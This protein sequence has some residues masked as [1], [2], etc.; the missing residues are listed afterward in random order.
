MGKFQYTYSDPTISTSANGD[1]PYGIYDNDTAFV[2][3]SVDVC[4]WTAKRLGHPV[5]QLEFN[6]SSILAN[7]PNT[8]N[9]YS[10]QSFSG[11]VVVVVLVLTADLTASSILFC[12]SS[13]LGPQEVEKISIKI[14]IKNFFII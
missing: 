3:E 7:K 10:L 6:S 8:V 14:N 5:M 4:K 12:T 2:S 13:S 9:M 11:R 1:T